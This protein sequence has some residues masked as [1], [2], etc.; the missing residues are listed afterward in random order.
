MI[1]VASIFTTADTWQAAL[2]K[3]LDRLD[4][5]AEKSGQVASIETYSIEKVGEDRYRIDFK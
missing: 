4:K 5:I 1:T 2:Y 3:A